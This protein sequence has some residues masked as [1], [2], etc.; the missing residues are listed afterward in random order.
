MHH[1]PPLVE[2]RV[3]VSTTELRASDPQLFW[4]EERAKVAKEQDKNRRIHALLAEQDT[5]SV[6]KFLSTRKDFLPAEH[7]F[8]E[9]LDEGN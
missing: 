3:P 9:W 5:L 1:Q 7:A 6:L 2:G 4:T 8:M